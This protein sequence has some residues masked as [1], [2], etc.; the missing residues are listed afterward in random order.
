MFFFSTSSLFTLEWS[1]VQIRGTKITL[2][3]NI[4]NSETKQNYKFNSLFGISQSKGILSF[5]LNG[6]LLV[7]ELEYL[8][9]EGRYF[10]NETAIICHFQKSF[11]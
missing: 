3:L 9:S 11:K 6:H 7:A 8:W 4:A 2:L 10:R 5:P 1:K